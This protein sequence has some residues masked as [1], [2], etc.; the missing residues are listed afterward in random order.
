M[1]KKYLEDKN[2][3]LLEHGYG[4]WKDITEEE[5]NKLINYYQYTF[6]K[7]EDNESSNPPTLKYSMQT[8]E[9]ISDEEY[10]N[11]MLL[12]QANVA[13]LTQKHIKTIKNCAIYFT[14]LSVLGILTWII[15]LL[16]AASSY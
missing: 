1:N 5:Y 7:I 6:A 13:D 8:A 11:I 2:M 10:Q 4:E 9:A 15:L 16:I 3:Y 12:E 14:V